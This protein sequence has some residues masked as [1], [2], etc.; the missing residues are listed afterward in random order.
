M[1]LSLGNKEKQGALRRQ[2]MQ[3]L[4]Q[5]I[6]GIIDLIRLKTEAMRFVA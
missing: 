6:P 5:T 4:I 3:D 2:E 1:G